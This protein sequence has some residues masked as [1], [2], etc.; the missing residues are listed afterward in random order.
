M[1]AA[2]MLAYNYR[3]LK[4]W[5]LA[6]VAYNH[7]PG[8]LARAAKQTGTRDL[9]TIIKSYY[10]NSFGFA[11]KNFYAEFLAASSIAMK[12]DSLYP[13]LRKMEPLQYQYL[14]LAKPISTR[15]A[16]HGDGADPGRAGGIQPGPASGDLP[17]TKCQ[18][19]KGFSLTT[20]HDRGRGRLGRQAGRQGRGDRRRSAHGNRYG[21]QGFPGGLGTA[22]S[23]QDKV[24]NR[25]AEAPAAGRS[26]ARGAGGSDGKIQA[27]VPGQG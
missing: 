14:I 2:K 9:G 3:W 24:E 20:A 17:R 6:I 11:S 25:M 12:A 15:Y 23:P 8:G 5:P 22:A 13:D 10:S 26:G 16:L 4:S 19:P 21:T 7:G 27:P 18:L 1:A